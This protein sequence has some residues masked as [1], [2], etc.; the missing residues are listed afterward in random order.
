MALFRQITSFANNIIAPLI[1]GSDIGEFVFSPYAQRDP[2]THSY[3]ISGAYAF[4]TKIS[5]HP[6]FVV[7]SVVS[8]NDI[9]AA[10][11]AYNDAMH[12]LKKIKSGVLWAINQRIG[13][14]LG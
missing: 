13:H 12:K 4:E 9:A 8:T 3:W 14:R 11:I 7:L 2:I 1:Y 6:T 10:S 5:F